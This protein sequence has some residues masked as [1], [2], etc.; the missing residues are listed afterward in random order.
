[1]VEGW[2]CMSIQ[3]ST[4]T[5]D[6]RSTSPGLGP[7]VSRSSTWRTRSSAVRSPVAAPPMDGDGEGDAG[8]DDA[9]AHAQSSERNMLATTGR[10]AGGT[11]IARGVIGWPKTE[12]Q[13]GNDD[14]KE[15]QGSQTP[16]GTRSRAAAPRRE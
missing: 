10:T 15:E 13:E 1:M 11:C 14:G 3:R 16:C 2:S 5:A 8:G 7:N 12:I 6:T 9:G 4:P